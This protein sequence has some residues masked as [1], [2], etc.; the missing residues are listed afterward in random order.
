ME[1]RPL[2]NYVIVEREKVKETRTAGGIII[3]EAL[4]EKKLPKRKILYKSEK[5]EHVEVGEI[6]LAAPHSETEFQINGKE[7]IAVDERNL[8]CAIKE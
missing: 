3:P 7:L 6:V 5:C 1:I 8:I 4:V 2:N